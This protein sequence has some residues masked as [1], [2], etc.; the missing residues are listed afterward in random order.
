MSP[1]CNKHLISIWSWIFGYNFVKPMLEQYLDA[2]L[3]FLIVQIHKNINF[4]KRGDKY[5]GRYHL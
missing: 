4:Y 2:V 3:A 5:Y 1:S